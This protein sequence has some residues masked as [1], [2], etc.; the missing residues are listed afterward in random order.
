MKIIILSLAVLLSGCV[1]NFQ[2]DPGHTEYHPFGANAPD[3]CAV[4]DSNIVFVNGLPSFEYI[5]NKE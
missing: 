4:A 5:C 2:H 1:T 3:N